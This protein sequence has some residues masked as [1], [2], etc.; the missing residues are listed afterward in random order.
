[1]G[2]LPVP[3]QGT[4]DNRAGPCGR[5]SLS[6]VLTR[7]GSQSPS[8]ARGIWRC[9]RRKTRP[10]GL[11][12]SRVQGTNEP[13]HLLRTIV[14]LLRESEKGRFICFKISSNQW[15][16]AATETVPGEDPKDAIRNRSGLEGHKGIEAILSR[17][18]TSQ[19]SQIRPC[20]GTVE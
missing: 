3:R 15:E 5:A 14:L 4:H 19:A 20:S 16:G 18:Q 11:M 2:C 13:H 17:S 12:V 7:P 9:C 6:A 10:A 1:M 8:A